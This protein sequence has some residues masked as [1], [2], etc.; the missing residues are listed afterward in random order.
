MWRHL[1]GVQGMNV[2]IKREPP[3]AD[4]PFKDEA[5]E[6]LRPGAPLEDYLSY[7]LFRIVNRVVRVYLT[8]AGRSIVG[9]RAICGLIQ[10]AIFSFAR[11]SRSARTFITCS[12]K[13]GVC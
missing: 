9:L 11:R 2:K 3:P 12:A 10:C 1:E 8:A 5:A 7:Q 13:S 4:Q 6:Q